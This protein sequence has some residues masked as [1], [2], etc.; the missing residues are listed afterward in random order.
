ISDLGRPSRFLAMLRVFKPQSPMSVGAWTL[1]AFSSVSLA[2]AFAEFMRQN[3]PSVP[4]TIL[5]NGC[6]TLSGLLGLPLA[7]YTGVLIGASAIPVWNETVHTLP[8]H[9]G[10]S[11]MNAAVSML[12]LM[13]HENRALNTLGLGASALETIEGFNVETCKARAL[14]PLKYGRNG[15]ITRLGGALGGP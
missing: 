7:T 3:F 10:M 4:V 8:I 2:A 14:R 5:G 15:L 12:E 9:F 1:A 13:G 11:G 6:G